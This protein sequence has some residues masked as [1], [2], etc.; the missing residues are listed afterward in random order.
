MTLLRASEK[1]KNPKLLTGL[2]RD[3]LIPDAGAGKALLVS[4]PPCKPALW[5]LPTAAH[6]ELGIVLESPCPPCSGTAYNFTAE[7]S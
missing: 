5:E 6:G 3:E 7:C 2:L 4:L 1:K